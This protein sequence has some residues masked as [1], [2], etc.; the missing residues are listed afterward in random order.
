[1]KKN[2]LYIIMLLLL[3]GTSN[4]LHAQK[5]LSLTDAL[6]MA[7]QGN[8]TIQI[9]TLE[10]IH[11]RELTRETK[12]GLLPN[13]S[14]NAAYSHYFDKQQIFLPG[15][16]A[17]TNKAVQDVAVGGRNT[18]NGFLSLNQ[19]IYA[20]GLH[21]LT[22]AALINEKIENEKT[23]KLKSQVALLV[24]TK[25]FDILMMNQQLNLLKQSLQRNIRAL[26]DSRSLF[27]QGRGLKADTLRSFIAVENLK[28]SVSYLNNNIDVSSIELK[29][30]IGMEE[31]EEIK[32]S[33]NLDFDSKANQSE[34]YKVDEALKIAETNRNDLNIQEL[35]IDFQQKKLQAAKAELL[36]QLSLI[37]QYQLQAQADNMNLDNY[38]WPRTSYLG[39][40]LSV[41]IFNGNRSNSQINQE[42][43]KVQQEKIRLIDLKDEIKT[44]LAIIISK[45]KEALTQLDIHQT[46]V[47]SAEL[48]YQMIE[49]RFKNGLSSRLELTDAELALTQ[50]KINYLNAVHNLRVL[51]VELQHA[52]GLLK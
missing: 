35:T 23:A 27:A 22:K 21:R 43:I 11:S 15:S 34:F 19:P 46:T 13:I 36:P 24:S 17:G 7:K 20:P 29:R 16:F 26:N 8:K 49:D 31:P 25:Y 14:A 40:Q 32:L 1:M 52:L 42:N 3:I 45:W 41:P 51:H 50:S 30:L 9:Q 38:T 48:N 6:E 47:K 10:E 12:G 37:G 44:E 4:P 33:D 2:I 18:Y 39:L 5:A 28:S